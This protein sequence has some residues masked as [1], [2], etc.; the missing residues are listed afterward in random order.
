MTKKR[1]LFSAAC[2]LIEPLGLLH[3]SGLARDL[4][5][6]RMIHL[7]PNHDFDSFFEKVRDF[8]PDIVGFNIYT[9]NHLQSHQAFKK[10]R[11]DYPDVQIV[12]GGPHPTYFPVDSSEHADFVV[13]SEGFG[14]LRQIM[15]GTAKKGILAMPGSEKFPQPDREIF[16]RDYPEHANSRI[17]SIISMT[18]CPYK[19]TYCYN[20]STPQDINVPPEIAEKLAQSMGYGGRLFPYNVRTIEDVIAEGR[21]IAEKWPTDLIYFQDDV[22]GF[23]VQDWLPKFAPRWKNEVTLPYHAQ[24]RWEMTRGDSGSQR[25]DV[26]KQAGCFGLTLAIEAA[27]ELIRKEVLDRGTSGD[28]M[29][30]G[31]QKLTDREFKVRTEQIT[32]L[33]YGATS[34]PTPMNLDADLELVELNVKLRESSGGPTMAWASTFVPYAG[35]KLGIYSQRFGHYSEW[36]NNGVADT[37]FDRSVL[38][39]PLGWIGP[40]LE[41]LTG[42]EDV[43]LG[44][45]DLERYR[46]QNAELRRIFNFVTLIPDGH[47]LAR[48]Y[49]ESDESYTFE[50]LGQS[51]IRHLQARADSNAEARRLLNQIE[52]FQI[53]VPLTTLD[54][55]GQS[56]IK[57]LVGYFGCLPKGFLAAKR[58]AKYAQEQGSY[59]PVILSTATR[60]HLYDE[61]LYVADN[62]PSKEEG[63]GYLR[64]STPEAARISKV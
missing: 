51:T 2:S 13:M 3:L 35:T 28:A 18:G 23:D 60:H 21:E 10:L 12:V 25:L 5:W 63:S 27:N 52:Q 20:S 39:F 48:T 17:K 22:H 36:D 54:P 29:F 32:A 50:R 9:G 24:M 42:K 41:K 26:L 19:C 6:D 62:V 16:Y 34:G 15:T 31:M 14:G 37:F 61:V 49:I 46:T 57:N 58:F 33:P 1:I 4:S 30:E 47:Q 44:R 64:S 8:R 59:S 56:V 53:Q 40:G 38:R 43:W 45:K 11:R 7:I 55:K